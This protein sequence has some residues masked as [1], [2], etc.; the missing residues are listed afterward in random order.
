MAWVALGTTAVGAG[1][2]YM[3]SKKAKGGQM[4]APG[5]IMA[6]EDKWAEGARKENYDYMSNMMSNVQAGIDPMQARRDQQTA[7]E[8]AGT[9][10]DFMGTE[11]DR[12]QGIISMGQQQ[13]AQFGANPAAMLA[14]KK[15]GQ[16]AMQQQ[17][18][19]IRQRIQDQGTD[20]MQKS[21]FFAPE[22]MNKLQTGAKTTGAYGPQMIPGQEAPSFDMAGISKGVEAAVGAFGPSVNTGV[23]NMKAGRGVSSLWGKPQQGPLMNNGQFT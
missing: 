19:D 15:K 4:M 14:Q 12:N 10:R 23:S 13:M 22:M 17:L 16:T 5:N 9:R 6:P 7:Y 8:Q 2:S 11:G 21:S 18:N 3:N 20:Y 1:M